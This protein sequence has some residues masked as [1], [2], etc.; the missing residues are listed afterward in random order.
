MSCD[1]HGKLFITLFMLRV[2]ALLILFSATAV[3]QH[4]EAVSAYV[5]GDYNRVVTLTQT[6]EQAADL[7][8]SARAVLAEAMSTEMGEPALSTLKQAEALAR[9]AIML[10]E[11][12]AEAR[13]QLAISLSLQARP[14]SNRQAMRSGLGQQ[15]RDIA[16]EILAD[17]PNNIYAH[18]L[19]AV[20][21]MEVLRRGGRIGARLMGASRKSARQHYADAAAIAPDD[22]SL[23]WQWARVLAATNARKYASEIN[24]ALNASVAA[25]T[26]DA[27]EEV[28][29]GRAARLKAAMD[30]D[31]F[32]AAKALAL[33]LL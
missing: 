21:N 6:S 10:D 11:R 12:Y 25:Q 13:V 19:L 27:L 15:S 29:Q 5:A 20:W 33:E 17:D 31:D 24:S 26:N 7:A 30:A 18:G 16:R 32:V 22:G 28:M 3:A 9:E 8:L 4:E 14:M 23:H 1:V 2:L